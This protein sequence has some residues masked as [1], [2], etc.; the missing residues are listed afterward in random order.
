MALKLDS[1][2]ELRNSEKFSKGGQNDSKL[3]RHEHNLHKLG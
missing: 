1:G 2:F 3:S